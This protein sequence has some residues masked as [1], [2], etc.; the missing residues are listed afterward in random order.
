M[1]ETEQVISTRPVNDAERFMQ[2][3][4][5]EA[6]AEQSRLMD[7][8]AQQLL[9]IELAIPG[10]YATMLKLI[11]GNEQLQLSCAMGLA[12]TCWLLAIIATVLAMLPRKYREVVRDSPDSIEAFF[13]QAARYK[14]CWLM[15]SIL[16]FVSGLVSIIMDLLL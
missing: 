15:G 5:S 16:L 7:T 14:R 6:I 2:E 1:S 4:F 9:M 11:S 13:D 8:M 3:R 12:F 10:L